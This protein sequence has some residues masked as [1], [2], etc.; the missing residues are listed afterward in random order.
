MRNAIVVLI[1]AVASV[2]HA[3]TDD[4][5]REGVAL[6]DQGK[7]DAAIAK[8]NETINAHPSLLTSIVPLRDGVS[9][10]LKL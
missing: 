3:Q 6:F 2:A 7:I 9:V 10:S 1:L 5:I 8:Y 4:R